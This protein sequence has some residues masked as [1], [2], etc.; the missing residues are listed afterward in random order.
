M[1]KIALLVLIGWCVF[2]TGT[3]SAENRSTP[4]LIEEDQYKTFYRFANSPIMKLPKLEAWQKAVPGV[5]SVTIRSSADG[6][7][8]PALFYDSGSKRKKPLLVVLHSWSADYLQRFSIPYGLW[9]AR[10]DW[11]FIHPD[12]RGPFTNPDST[13]SEKAVRDILDALQYARA[14][15]DV[16]PARIYLAGFSGGAM[17]T[18]IMAGRHPEHWAGAVA[19]VPVYDLIA[20]YESSKGTRYDYY[21]GH[22]ANSCGGVPLPGS[23]AEKEC[24]RRSPI[25]YLKN[26]RTRE[27]PVYIGTGIRDPL[28]PPSHALRAFN[29]LAEPGD[30]IPDETIAFIEERKK[31]PPRFPTPAQDPLY[32]DAGLRLL[33]E[34]KS[35]NVTLKIFDGKHDVIYNA[36][37]VWLN[38]RRK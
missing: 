2:L 35:A 29:D 13:G 16:D 5:R 3:L 15:A 10:N 36:G 34:R 17:A 28:V 18:L 20:W 27:V 25:S 26:A 33:F 8:Q 1:K 23:E 22:I 7:M 24:L 37:L 32:E 9:A 4:L 21:A 38:E 31:L 14:E 19:W 30:R 11:V 12:Y 6:S